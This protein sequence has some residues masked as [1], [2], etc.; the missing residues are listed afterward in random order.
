MGAVCAKLVFKR[1]E[2]ISKNK[3]RRIN[4]SM[5]RIYSPQVNSG[6]VLRRAQ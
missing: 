2:K 3:G 5:V 6:Q 4:P 1:L